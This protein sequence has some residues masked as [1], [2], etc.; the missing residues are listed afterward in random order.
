[1]VWSQNIRILTLVQKARCWCLGTSQCTY[2]L[3]RVTCELLW[4]KLSAP[5]DLG[6]AISS[7]Q[8]FFHFD[9]SAVNTA[10]YDPQQI[11]SLFLDCANESNGTP[12]QSIPFFF[13][14]GIYRTLNAIDYV[15]CS[16]SAGNLRGTRLNRRNFLVHSTSKLATE[17]STKNRCKYSK[18]KRK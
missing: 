15:G 12:V 8:L 6:Q 9:H 13:T 18:K 3:F 16:C 5:E 2:G 7:Q 14:G 11:F 17:I 1:M 4:W 10:P